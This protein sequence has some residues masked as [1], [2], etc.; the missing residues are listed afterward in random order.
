M[1]RLLIGDESIL[2][3]DRNEQMAARVEAEPLTTYNP[4]QG[5]GRNARGRGAGAW[6][7]RRSPRALRCA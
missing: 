2:I 4:F 6:H 3:T 5:A 1:L 7:G